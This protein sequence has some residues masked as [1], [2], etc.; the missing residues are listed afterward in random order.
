MNCRRRRAGTLLPQTVGSY[1]H[2]QETLGQFLGA[3]ALNSVPKGSF[4]VDG[5]RQLR[6]SRA[7]GVS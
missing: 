7:V 4:L 3:V 2:L 5:N 6:K 1:F